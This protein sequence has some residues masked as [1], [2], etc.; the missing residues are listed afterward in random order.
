MVYNL[1]ILKIF[2]VIFLYNLYNLDI[3]VR[4]QGLLKVDPKIVFFFEL[5]FTALSR[6]FHLYR[7]DHSSKVDQTEEKSPAEL[8]F[9]NKNV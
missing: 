7:A 2:M 9:P 1:Y 6:I 4:I 3:F 5:G 8:L